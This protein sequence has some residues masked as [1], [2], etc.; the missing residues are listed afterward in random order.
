MFVDAVADR[1]PPQHRARP[2]TRFA[3]AALSERG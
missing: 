1:I 3:P 2:K